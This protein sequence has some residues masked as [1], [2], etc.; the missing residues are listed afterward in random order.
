MHRTILLMVIAALAATFAAGCDP[1]GTTASPV[2]SANGLVDDEPAVDTE[3]TEAVTDIALEAPVDES[4]PEDFEVT[5]TDNADTE[6]VSKLSFTVKNISDTELAFTVHVFAHGIVGSAKKEIGSAVLSLGESAEF[7]INASHIPVRSHVAV[8]DLSVKIVR[9]IDTPDG[10]RDVTNTFAT[11]MY[12]H[13]SGYGTVRTY[14]ADSLEAELGG[15]IL[16]ETTGKSDDK[17]KGIDLDAAADEVIG[18]ISDAEGGFNDVTK[19]NAGIA[20]KGESADVTHS[21]KRRVISEE[22]FEA[23]VD[24]LTSMASASA[25]EE[26][27]E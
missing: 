6:A 8:N 10:P 7:E 27:V 4:P 21:V 15:V 25:P 24:S 20:N 2:S 3:G 11:R 16:E 22:A 23:I 12:R 26:E 14:T 1:G 18:E 5:W 17:I 9:T 19:E 13:I